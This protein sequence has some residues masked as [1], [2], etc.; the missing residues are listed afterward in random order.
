[1][2]SKLFSKLDS[3]LK[4]EFGKLD[5]GL[6]N[7]HY[8]GVFLVPIAAFIKNATKKNATIVFVFQSKVDFTKL[9]FQKRV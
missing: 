4:V 8:S 7:E 2:R 6:K 9:D 5:F 3:F 1:M